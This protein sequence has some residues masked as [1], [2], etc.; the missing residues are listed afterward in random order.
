MQLFL[1]F[2]CLWSIHLYMKKGI[3]IQF[4]SKRHHY[5]T[6]IFRFL[7]LKTITNSFNHE[8]LNFKPK[9]NKNIQNLSIAMSAN[10]HVTTLLTQYHLFWSVVLKSHL[11]TS[12]AVRGLLCT[13]SFQSVPFF[14]VTLHPSSVNR[15]VHLSWKYF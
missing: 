2:M 9:W 10:S 6:F 11:W 8:T 1:M 7:T 3:M 5:L 4:Y 12:S 15:H 14:R 13:R